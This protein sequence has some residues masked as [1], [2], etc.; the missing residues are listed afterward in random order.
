MLLTSGAAFASLDKKQANSFLKRSRRATA[1]GWIDWTEEFNSVAAWEEFKDAL[2]E[3]SIPESELE[4]LETCQTKCSLRDTA[5]DFLGLAYIAFESL[6]SNRIR[7]VS[8]DF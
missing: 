6:R 7:R 5:L 8:R 1:L 4:M 2:D 3:T